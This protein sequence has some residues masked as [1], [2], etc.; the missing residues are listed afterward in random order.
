VRLKH[1]LAVDKSTL[2][3][4][5]VVVDIKIQTLAEEILKWQIVAY[6]YT[7]FQ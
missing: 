6:K 2:S 5:L 4:L 1:W 3:L 7:H